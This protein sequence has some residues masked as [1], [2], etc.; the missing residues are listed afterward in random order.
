MSET[1]TSE[2][3]ELPIVTIRLPGRHERGFLRRMRKMREVIEGSGDLM[4]MWE[5]I[6]DHLVA[7]GYVEAPKGVDVRE[8]IAD[9]SQSDIQT[10]VG[11]LLGNTDEA[12]GAGRSVN[13]P[14]GG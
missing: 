5:G 13:P 12:R 14:N 4:A 7:E 1:G 10:I 3:G 9:M 6:A 11:A 2:T 8:A